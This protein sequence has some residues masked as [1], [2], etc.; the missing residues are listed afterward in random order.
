MRRI[1]TIILLASSSFLFNSCVDDRPFIEP[2][3]AASVS[4]DFWAGA[5]NIEVDGEI[6]NEGN[7]FI[8]RVE[9]E[10]QLFDE[11]NRYVRSVFLMQVV[12]LDP[13]Q[14]VPFAL[15]VRERDIYDVDVF[16]V[17]IE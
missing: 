17:S 8:H 11:F 1:I 15:D 9:L 2:H 13:N 3:P 12:N 14:F 4:F 5:R 16:V 7:T 6:I 10:V